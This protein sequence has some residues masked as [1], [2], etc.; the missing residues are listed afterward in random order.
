[1]KLAVDLMG[2]DQPPE[3]LFD[4]VL[5]VRRE[6]DPS[7]T[8]VVIAE[9][10][11]VPEDQGIEVIPS[12]ESIT[13]EDS[14]LLAVRR[15]KNS[16]MAIGMR[17]LKEKQIDGLVSTGNTGALIANSILNLSMLPSIDRPAFLVMLPTQKGGVAVLDVGANVQFKPHHLIDYA[18]MGVIY[19]QNIQGIEQPTVGL[20]NIGVEEGKG[21]KE[22]KVAFQSLQDHFAQNEGCFLGNIEGKDVFHGKV[23]VLVT[24][25]FTG[26]VFL[27]T[28]EGASAFLSDYLAENFNHFAIKPIIS[29]LTQKFNYSVHPGALLCGVDGLV[30]KCHGYSD[31]AALKS[32]IRGAVDL[33][34][35]DLIAKMKAQ[36]S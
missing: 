6:I 3:L 11:A 10:G 7:C 35:K 31:Q 28:C 26:N 32:G 34:Q 1:M 17:L 30:V 19:K 20:L 5:Q 27:K 2:G 18:R 24:D 13:M 29:R 23:D 15:K 33:A 8:L 22:V 12:E 9:P 25:G 4:A 36:L 16:S 21:T 14:P